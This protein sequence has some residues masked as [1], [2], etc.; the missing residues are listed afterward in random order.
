MQQFGRAQT[1]GTEQKAEGSA[2]SFREQ[3][4]ALL[5]RLSAFAHCLTGKCGATRRS[6]SGDLCARFSAQGSV[7]SRH[8]FGP[9]D[10]SHRAETFGS[11]RSVQRSLVVSPWTWRWPTIWWAAMGVQSQRGG[12]CSLAAEILRLPVGTVMSRLARGRLALYDATDGPNTCTATSTLRQRAVA[13]V[14]D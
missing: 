10:V 2:N 8:A 1:G 11:I 6:Y 4:I 3:I 9:L 12:S 5:P 14:A 13:E 7:A